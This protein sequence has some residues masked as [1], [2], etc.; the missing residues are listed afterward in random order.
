[1]KTK[2][3]IFLITGASSGLGLAIT[4][5]LIEKNCKLILVAR[6][7]EILKEIR[8]K[9]PDNIEIYSGDL[10]D[11]NFIKEITDNLPANLSGVFIN[12]GGPPASNFKETSIDDW[13]NGYNLLIKWKVELLK[14]VMPILENNRKGKVIFSES[15]SITKPIENLLLSNSLR[16]SIIGLMKSMVLE[17]S[18]YNITFNILAPGYHKTNALERIYKKISLE[19]SIS[20]EEAK[21]KVKSSIPLGIV[22]NAADYADLATWIFTENS[23]YITGQVINI[24][25]GVST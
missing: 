14:G 3:D 2:R 13:Q 17:Y 4:E 6:R 15:N 25:G 9:H 16:M 22:G 1:M 18:K 24:D 23:G 21:D 5:K 10:L 8:K 12:A 11:T 19:N 7:E 20:I